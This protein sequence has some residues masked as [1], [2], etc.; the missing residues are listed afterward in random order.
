[1]VGGGEGGGKPTDEVSKSARSM[2]RHRVVGRREGTKVLVSVSGRG[3]G[4]RGGAMLIQS[5][6]RLG[7]AKRGGCGWRKGSATGGRGGEGREA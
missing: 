2:I 3:G 1:M 6:F 5:Y 4:A 7:R